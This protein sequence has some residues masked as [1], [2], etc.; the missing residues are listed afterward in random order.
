VDSVKDQK[1]VE[2]ILRKTNLDTAGSFLAVGG[3]VLRKAAV[4]YEILFLV[5]SYFPAG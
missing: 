2:T 1:S 3:T 5:Y 4:D